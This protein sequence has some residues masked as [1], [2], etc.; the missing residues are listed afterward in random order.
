MARRGSLLEDLMDLISRAAWP[1]GLG[2]AVVSY[3]TLHWAAN[4]YS[5]P[6]APKT[7]ADL[8]TGVQRQIIHTLASILQ[9]VIPPVCVVGAIVSFVRR[10]RGVALFNRA[11]VGGAPAVAALSWSQFEQVIGE[12]F[13]QDGY[14]VS[15]N[16]GS[17]PDG[18]VDL[19]LAKGSD[20]FLVQCKHW[21]KMSVGVTVIREFYGVMTSR[22]VTGG[23][24]V[25]SGSFTPDAEAFASKCR[26]ELIDGRRLA[27]WMTRAS[28]ATASRPQEGRSAPG[29][30]VVRGV[31]VTVP[32][33]RLCG[34]TM[35]MRTARRGSSVGQQFWG[36]QRFPQCRETLAL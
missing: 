33:C 20:R 26:I 17:G 13:R 28:A 12:A 1:I 18:G 4:Q 16:V 15:G 23:F 2:L 34:S 19:V 10:S 24:V 36:C 29:E 32:R 7:V 22:A 5:V 21:R 8:G 9:F 11:V 14:T 27:E 3:G 25:A 30:S 31:E 6:I 35:I